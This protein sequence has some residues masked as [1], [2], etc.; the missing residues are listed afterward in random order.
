MKKLNSIR[1][2]QATFVLSSLASAA[3]VQYSLRSQVPQIAFVGQQYQW[4]FSAGT[5]RADQSDHDASSLTYRADSLPSWLLF[6]PI[7]RTFSGTPSTSDVGSRTLQIYAAEVDDS[8][9]V[10]S[11]QLIVSSDT[12]PT[13]PNN[14]AKQFTSD[15]DH[16]SSADVVTE[17]SGGPG[18]RIRQAWSFSIGLRWDTFASPNGRKIHYSATLANRDPLPS[19]ISFDEDQMTFDGVTP[20]IRSEGDIR[21]FEITLYGAEREGYAAIE[22][23]F[24]FAI[25]G[26]LW[27][28][29]EDT[30][31]THTL[32]QVAPLTPVNVSAGCLFSY[33]FD[34]Y[35][36]KGLVLDEEIVQRHNLTDIL[37]DA[38]GYSWLSYDNHTSRLSGTPPMELLHESRPVIPIQVLAKYDNLSVSTNFTL[39]VLPSAFNS[40]VIPPVVAQ[41]SSHLSLD[42]NQYFV[43]G[44]GGDPRSLAV[45]MTL[46]PQAAS[47]WLSLSQQAPWVVSGTVPAS[48]GYTSLTMT[49]HATN[50][51]TNATSIA[52]VLT[53][54][55]PP[56]DRSLD[57]AVAHHNSVVIGATVGTIVGVVFLLLLFAFYRWFWSKMRQDDEVEPYE[58]DHG[59][60]GDRLAAGV[61]EAK[62][63]GAAGYAQYGEYEKAEGEEDFE[64]INLDGTDNP[65]PSRPMSVRSA[66]SSAAHSTDARISKA[67]FFQKLKALSERSISSSNNSG[68][69]SK[70][71]AR[72]K[73]NVA[74]QPSSSGALST[75]GRIAMMF[76]FVS[77]GSVSSSGSRPV[78]GR[79][80]PM[81][82]GSAGAAY[83]IG[84]RTGTT[85]S[86]PMS[87]SPSIQSVTQ[88][89]PAV[90]PS[91]STGSIRDDIFRPPRPR[92]VSIS[93]SLN[94]IGNKPA[95]LMAS[96][97]Q[98][99][100]V[101]STA[102][103]G[104][105]WEAGVDSTPW[106]VEPS[107]VWASGKLKASPQRRKGKPSIFWCIT[108][109]DSSPQ[110]LQVLPFPTRAPPSTLSCPSVAKI[111][112]LRPAL[113]PHERKSAAQKSNHLAR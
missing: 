66:S 11:F 105:T 37:V 102:E 103:S 93:K 39:N 64:N 44:T 18:V 59:L 40:A 19:W 36:F 13:E 58:I 35:D 83:K 48:V 20:K 62:R 43:N 68:P 32:S 2:A 70:H 113:L 10:D 80:M 17:T 15:N 41:P 28:D 53:N 14:F 47:K 61:A 16:I 9:T 7:S 95:P 71:H 86:P 87:R 24:S 4:A 63:A 23:T 112:D 33:D 74:P 106:A 30:D 22:D 21:T 100:G 31:A 56:Q 78:I 42:L 98:N 107:F 49:F 84:M 75:G 3:S 46:E 54:L 96:S 5:F 104:E 94:A 55:S 34:F 85:P 29:E 91:V 99:S 69:T 67:T 60:H 27:D 38:R 52:T 77:R 111:S 76:G 51:V 101:A 26:P 109:A 50:P 1:L 88:P 73:E 25:E 6:D 57:G 90:L 72:G 45:T 8:E 81:P 92:G 65:Y 110:V 79:P 82:P 89:P 108:V 12:P 97:S